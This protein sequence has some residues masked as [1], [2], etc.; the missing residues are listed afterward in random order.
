MKFRSIVIILLF[1]AVSLLGITSERKKELTLSAAGIKTLEIECGSGYLKVKGKE[2]LKQIEVEATIVIKG[3]DKDEIDFFIK[4]KI[5]LTLKKKGAKAEL[6]SEVKS[7]SSIFGKRKSVQVNLDVRMPR[8]MSLDIDDGSGSIA[9]EGIGADVEIED[10]SGSIEVED[11]NGDLEIEDGSGEIDIEGV[12][13]NVKIDDGSGE[14]DVKKVK[15][16]VKVDDSSGEIKVKNI[17]GD[18]DVEDS[19][20]DIKIYEIGG[21]VVVDDGSGGIY[22]DGVAKDVYIKSA[23]SGS[24]SIKNV[25]GK[26]EK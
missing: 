6:V 4:D 25:K 15:G 3:L 22:I 20:G 8:D 2:G 12:S 17:G 19:S 10:G 7:L 11:I 1:A 23:G 24:V 16:N 5:T 21:S 26:V 18:V 13:G 14:I 9:V